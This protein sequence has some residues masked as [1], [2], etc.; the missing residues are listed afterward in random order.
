[1][2]HKSINYHSRSVV[3]M[4]TIS[5]KGIDQFTGGPVVAY[6]ECGKSSHEI[7]RL[8]GINLQTVS[9]IV[10]KGKQEG[11]CRLKKLTGRPNQVYKRIL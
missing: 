1:M 8:L 5:V 6:Y 4:K 11:R 10:G 2:I 3:I 7:R 9:N